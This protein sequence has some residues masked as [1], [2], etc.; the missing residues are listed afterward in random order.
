MDQQSA[1]WNP[2]GSVLINLWGLTNAHAHQRPRT[3]DPGP[4]TQDPGPWTLDPGPRTQDPGPR[5]QAAGRCCCRRRWVWWW[6]SFCSKDC[7]SL[8]IMQSNKHSRLLGLKMATRPL[9]QLTQKHLFLKDPC[10]SYEIRKI[11][12][13]ACAGNA[14]NIEVGGG[15]NVPGVWATRNFTYLVRGP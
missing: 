13:C 2:V 15:E 10:A 5:T 11:E 6:N 1:V 9:P 4:R 3:Q 7:F 8:A 14:G 12:G